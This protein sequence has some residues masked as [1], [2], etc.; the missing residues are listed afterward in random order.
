MDVVMG[1]PV[2]VPRHADRVNESH[3]DQKPPG[4]VREDEKQRQEYAL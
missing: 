4:C 1:D 2:H 3:A